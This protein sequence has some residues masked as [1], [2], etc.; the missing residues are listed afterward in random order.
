MARD[1][2]V[3]PM[4]TV[5]PMGFSWAFWFALRIFQHQTLIALRAGPEVLLQDQ[6]P[7]PSVEQGSF[8]VMTYCDNLNI[9]SS[10]PK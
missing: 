1:G 10:D 4:L 5:M 9:A 8:C 3:W 7:V 2:W 6:G